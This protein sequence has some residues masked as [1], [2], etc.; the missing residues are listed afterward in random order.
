MKKKKQQK[1]RGRKRENYVK[2]SA[3]VTSSEMCSG[4]FTEVA[5]S[6]LVKFEVLNHYTPPY[7][8]DD[9]NYFIRFYI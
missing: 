8:S 9:Y 1:Q 5:Y 4:R 6:T 3:P 7:L 2:V